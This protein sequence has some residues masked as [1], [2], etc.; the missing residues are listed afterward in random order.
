MII[1]NISINENNNTKISNK[2][3]LKRKKSLLKMRKEIQNK[4]KINNKRN[5]ISLEYAK[6]KI[7]M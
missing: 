5:I 7:L 3:L 2:K 6:N 1:Y 4:I